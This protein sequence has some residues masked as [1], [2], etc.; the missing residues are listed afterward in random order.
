MAT[1]IS[2]SARKRSESQH[3]GFYDFLFQFPVQVRVK[4][5]H[6]SIENNKLDITKLSDQGFKGTAGFLQFC[7]VHPLNQTPLLREFLLQDLQRFQMA[8]AR[9][10]SK[11]SLEQSLGQRKSNS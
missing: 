2:S 9:S 5:P 4:V 6:P 7:H 1:T 3:I 8:A 11:R 10:D